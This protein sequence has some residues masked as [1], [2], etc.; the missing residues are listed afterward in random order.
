MKAREVE[1]PLAAMM[2]RQRVPRVIRSERRNLP[3]KPKRP[4]RVPKVTGYARPSEEE[5]LP[6]TAEVRRRALGGMVSRFSA[7]SGSSSSPRD[8]CDASC[9]LTWVHGLGHVRLEAG[10]ERASCIFGAR[11]RGQGDGRRPAT[12]FA[13]ELAYL[14]N[15]S[16]SIDDRQADV[17]HEDV[18][19]K[20]SQMID[21]FARRS[22]EPH[23]RTFARK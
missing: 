17:T 20:L 5:R 1:L 8:R 15:Q 19:A 13:G 7:R 14:T 4:S 22:G 10:L 9:Q 6:S 16:V 21:R 12:L 2:P 11:V 23:R 3:P 18:G